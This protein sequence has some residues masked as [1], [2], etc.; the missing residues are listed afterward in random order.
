MEKLLRQIEERQQQQA[1]S[2]IVRVKASE[3]EQ[4]HEAPYVRDGPFRFMDLPKDVRL[5][6]YDEYVES[7][8]A[9]T[10]L[11]LPAYA[12][13]VTSWTPAAKNFGTALALSGACRLVHEEM[14]T[15]VR[16][17]RLALRFRIDEDYVRAETADVED[18]VR[19]LPMEAYAHQNEGEGEGAGNGEVRV[20]QEIE[21]SSFPEE[22]FEKAVERVAWPLLKMMRA[23]QLVVGNSSPLVQ[24][25]LVTDEGRRLAVEYKSTPLLTC[26]SVRVTVT[27]VE[28]EA[29]VRRVTVRHGPV[30]SGI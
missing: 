7:L 24:L 6:V 28:E 14:E 17:Y 19:G 2:Q 8:P 16:K 1:S 26:P 25:V 18:L 5:M 29:G 22:G 11:L 10:L 12:C 23:H 13:H 15:V 20:P 9:R 4:I 21:V 27:E 3:P 30:P